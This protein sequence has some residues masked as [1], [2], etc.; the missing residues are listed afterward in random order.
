VFALAFVSR[1]VGAIIFGHIGDRVG[2]RLS[3]LISIAAMALP[4][5]LIGCL[6]PYKVGV[7]VPR[8]QKKSIRHSCTAVL[9]TITCSS[10][11]SFC[12]AGNRR[13]PKKQTIGMAAPAILAVLRVIQGL[14]VGGEYGTAVVYASELAPPGWE[15]RHGC[16]IVSFCQLVRP[17]WPTPHARPSRFTHGSLFVL[18]FAPT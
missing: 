14:A 9:L 16:F 2:R 13:H 5:I 18:C 12:N 17:V 10:S 7:R 8:S 1:P 6:P 11:I 15:A 4:T 3:L